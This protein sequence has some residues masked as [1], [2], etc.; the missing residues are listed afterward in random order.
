MRLIDADALIAQIEEIN[1]E[2]NVSPVGVVLNI[3]GEAPTVTRAAELLDTDNDGRVLILPAAKKNLLYRIIGNEIFEECVYDVILRSI[4]DWSIYTDLGKT[5]FLTRE[6][7]ETEL[8]KQRG[9]SYE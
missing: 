9:E 8:A 2:S 7:A 1:C 5:V 6:E 3:I 4:G